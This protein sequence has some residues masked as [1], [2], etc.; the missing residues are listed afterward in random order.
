MSAP[1]ANPAATAPAEMTRGYCATT[2]GQIH[3][4][5][6]G[7]GPPLVLLPQ[8]GRSSQM[9]LGLIRA[10]SDRYHVVALDMPGSGGSAALHADTTYEAIAASFIEAIDALGLG[11]VNLYGLHTGNKL[12]AAMAAA[13]PERIRRFV[14]AGQSH[15]II[16]DQNARNAAIAGTV[17]EIV[18]PRPQAAQ[19]ALFDWTAKLADIAA[20]GLARATLSGILETASY[21]EPLERAIDELQAM[22]S[23]PLLY[24]GNFAYDL[25]RDLASLRVPTLVLEIVTPE[26]DREFGRQGETLL[27]LIPDA[28][29]TTHH[30]PGGHGLTMEHRAPEIAAILSRFFG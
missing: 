29:L 6:A 20:L 27:N 3:Y 14:F 18:A 16:P 12:G 26:E 11:P 4:R 15:S 2:L 23:R 30:E 24:A 17:S 21:D 22:R 25:G 5:M 19:A 10:L 9:Y 28:E 13:A 7:S 1:R 8:S